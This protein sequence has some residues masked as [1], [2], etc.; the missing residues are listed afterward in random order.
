MSQKYSSP[1][2]TALIAAC[3]KWLWQNTPLNQAQISS[4]LGAL[5]QGRVS[6]VVNGHRFSNVQP[7]EFPGWNKHG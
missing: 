4:L 1:C 3:I 6:E 7:I 5:N 2:L